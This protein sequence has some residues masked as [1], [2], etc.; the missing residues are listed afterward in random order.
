MIK[1][2]KRFAELY[3]ELGVKFEIVNGILWRKYNRI[4]VP[5]GPAKL[6]YSISREEARFLLTKFGKALLVRWTD[7]F[8]NNPENISNDGWYAVLCYEFKDLPLLS[9]KHRYNI[10]RG[11]KNC[12]VKMVDAGFIANNGFNVYASA[13]SRYKDIKKPFLSE[14]E[15]KERILKTKTFD[16]II[17]YWGVFYN[18]NLIAYS[19]NYIYNNIE[20]S[21]S[22]IKFHPDF[23]RLY[24]SYAIIFEMNK[25]YLR[26]NRF[27]YVNDGFRSI[28]HQTNIQDYLIR[29]FNFQK[30]YTN[31]SIFYQRYLSIYL[32]VTFP[33]RKIFSKLSPKLTSLY[34]Q[35]EIRRCYYDMQK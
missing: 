33:M 32:Y 27:E 19:E 9:V 1:F 10:K 13:F 24:S 16:D 28:L 31:L 12:E 3:E 6:D 26:D 8:N 22:T 35:E 30:V 21:Y 17:N 25:F 18:N 20:V 23:L 11:L 34:K 14:K 15:F 4:I 2:I 29:S 7:G 5:L